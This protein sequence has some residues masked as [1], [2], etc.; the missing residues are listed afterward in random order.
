[1]GDASDNIKGVPGIGEKTAIKLIKAYGSI[2]NL[3]D[4]VEEL[5]QKKHLHLLMQR[6]QQGRKERLKIHI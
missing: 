1:M 6:Q 5:K 3:L 2:E 4:H